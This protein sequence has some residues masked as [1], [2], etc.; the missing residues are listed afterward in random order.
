MVAAV[1]RNMLAAVYQQQRMAVLDG[2]GD[3]VE[4]VSSMPVRSM[5]P[6]AAAT[7]DGSEAGSMTGDKSHRRAPA[8]K[9]AA[10]QAASSTATG[11]SCP[12]RLDH[13]VGPGRRPAARR[14][15]SAR[16]LPHERRASGGRL[17]DWTGEARNRGNDAG[18]AGWTSC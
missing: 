15:S 13:E 14:G 8:A 9:R 16:R 17:W 1:S 18:M 6:N 3:V 7:M 5:I 2:L 12:T 4:R 11:G 10:A